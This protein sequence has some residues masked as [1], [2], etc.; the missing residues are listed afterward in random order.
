[1]TAWA[2]ADDG[3][4]WRRRDASTFEYLPTSPSPELGPDG[5]PQVAVIVL[6]DSALVTVGANWDPPAEALER[7]RGRLAT[8]SGRPAASVRIAPPQLAMRCAELMLGNGHGG[9]EP[10][11]QSRT[12]GIAPYAA[13]FSATVPA[14]AGARASQALHGGRGWLA[15][16]YRAELDGQPLELRADVGDWT[17]RPEPARDQAKTGS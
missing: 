17:A 3:I 12:S 7:L 10:I 14:E 1:M 6:G 9:F 15:V 4:R 8:S 13:V 16:R 11:A 5:A 2:V